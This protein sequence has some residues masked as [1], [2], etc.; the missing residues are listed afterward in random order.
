[1]HLKRIITAIAALPLLI[2]VL[3]MSGVFVFTVIIVAVAMIAM[4]EYYGIVF[5]RCG[6]SVKL[7]ITVGYLSG[8]LLIWTQYLRKPDLLA[9][10][11]AVN[12]IATGFISLFLYE[13]N[14]EIFSEA[15]KQSLGLVYIPLFIS[16]FILIRDSDNGVEWIYFLLAVVFAGDIGAFYT[17]FF[18]GRTKLAPAISP[19][20]T[21]EGSIGGIFA[22]IVAGV[23][24]KYFFLPQ[25]EWSDCMLIAIS[26]GIAGQVGDLFESELKRTWNIKDSGEILPGHGGILDRIDAL[27]FAAPLLYFIKEIVL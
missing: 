10:V 11:L 23:S 8:A 12:L 26:I 16:F 5:S 15:A 22:N 1:M 6:A 20:K 21:L 19:N 18:L 13:K 25:V 7:F 3:T 9:I 4:Y 14:R 2:A 27:L 24:I 17:G